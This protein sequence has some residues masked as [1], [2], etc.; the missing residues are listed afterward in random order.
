MKKRFLFTV[1]C[2]L[3]LSACSKSPSADFYLLPAPTPL[4]QGL[5]LTALAVQKPQMPEYLQRSQMVLRADNAAKVQIEEYHRWAEDLSTAFQRV[6]CYALDNALL[7]RNVD[8]QPARIGVISPYKLNIYVNTFEGDLDKSASI[9]V[10]WTLDAG[11][12]TVL[13]GVYKE[14]IDVGNNHTKLVEAQSKLIENLALSI[15][16]EYK[17]KM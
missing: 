10:V 2:F 7:D 14:S 13:K 6:L 4:A 5:N 3:L 8:A 15:A 11:N 9:D 17:S 1:C 12:R 16:D